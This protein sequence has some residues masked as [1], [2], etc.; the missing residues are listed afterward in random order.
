MAKAYDL[1]DLCEK[2]FHESVKA[3]TVMDKLTALRK[4]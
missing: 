1:M 4:D 2:A 3:L